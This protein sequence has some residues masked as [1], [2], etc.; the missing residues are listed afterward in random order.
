MDPKKFTWRA[1]AVCRATACA[2][3]AGGTSGQKFGGGGTTTRVP[4]RV[5]CQCGTCRI[6]LSA[7]GHGHDSQVSL[8][9]HPRQA[10][11]PPSKVI[12]APTTSDSFR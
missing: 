4:T 5:R 2:A 9:R 3:I 8:I 10:L 7:P 12:A 11:Q 6:T 1:F